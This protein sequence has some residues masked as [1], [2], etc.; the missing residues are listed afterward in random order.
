MSIQNDQKFNIYKFPE[1]NGINKRTNNTRIR[2][3]GIYIFGGKS[4]YSE[5][6]NN[7]RVIKIGKKPLEFITLKCEGKPQFTKIFNKY[8]F[9]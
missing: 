5:Q 2:E 9:F 7:L 6:N 8:K 1:Q 3:K 4:K